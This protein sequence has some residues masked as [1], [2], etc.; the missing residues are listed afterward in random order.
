MEKAKVITDRQFNEISRKFNGRLRR[1]YAL[2]RIVRTLTIVVYSGV[3]LWLGYCL[4]VP[5]SGN[6]V[7]M[8]SEMIFCSE[9]FI[10]S[11][12]LIITYCSIQKTATQI[13]SHVAKSNPPVEIPKTPS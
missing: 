9:P 8:K 2:R 5:L 11:N 6:I 4:Y 10:A 7:L 1:L 13:M 12:P 3:L